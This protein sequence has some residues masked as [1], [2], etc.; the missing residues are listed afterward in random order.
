MSDDW[1][2]EN[3]KY[4]D[5][6]YGRNRSWSN[7]EEQNAYLAGQHRRALEEEQKKEEADEQARQQAYQDEQLRNYLENRERKREER[8]QRR[9]ERREEKE[10]NRYNEWQE[11]LEEYS[12]QKDELNNELNEL[13]E[14]NANAE[15]QVNEAN[16][17]LRSYNET[18]NSFAKTFNLYSQNDFSLIAN[19]WNA[20]LNGYLYYK[21]YCLVR[22]C[23]IEN[24]QIPKESNS[25]PIVHYNDNPKLYIHRALQ[26]F[27]M[28]SKRNF[29]KTLLNNLIAYKDTPER[30]VLDII[31]LSNN[32]ESLKELRPDILNEDIQNA[33][34]TINDPNKL[35]KYVAIAAIET[36]TILSTT[37]YKYDNKYYY[38]PVLFYQ[39]MKL[40]EIA[41]TYKNWSQEEFEVEK[42]LQKYYS[43][44]DIDTGR[45]IVNDYLNVLTKRDQ[46]DILANLDYDIRKFAN[47]S[48]NLTNDVFQ[49]DIYANQRHQ[50]MN[51][52]VQ[53]IEMGSQDTWRQKKVDAMLELMPSYVEYKN[54][55]KELQLVKDK[56]DADDNDATGKKQAK[57]VEK[58]YKREEKTS[59][60]NLHPEYNYGRVVYPNTGDYHW[61]LHQ[62]EKE[63]KRYEKVDRKNERKK[64]GKGLF[65]LFSNHQ[66]D[67][68]DQD[69]FKF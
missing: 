7:S 33:M 47:Y 40:Q 62:L 25:K 54:K 59:E 14:R 31:E 39:F 66:N 69:D 38:N 46:D 34:Q 10:E 3:S 30:I 13:L 52:Y 29:C 1:N 8:Q 49:F 44:Q 43:K 18:T 20:V 56:I 41:N 17:K 45:E 11:R 60:Y 2:F 67:V 57:A 48:G 35:L 68:D 9:E 5:G 58:K 26:Y 37:A 23:Q 65:G 4:S 22:I 55:Q 63:E 28:D 50:I 27:P 12:Q 6:Y 15:K 64:Q 32:T 36:R 53:E 24:D 42:E 16:A 21:N 19:R 51:T 61:T